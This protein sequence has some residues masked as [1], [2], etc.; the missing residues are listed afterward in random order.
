MQTIN[1]NH[2]YCLSKGHS[3]T[4]KNT[5]PWLLQFHW[6]GGRWSVWCETFCFD[7]TFLT[8]RCAWLSEFTK[9]FD[10]FNIYLRLI[11]KENLI[12]PALCNDSRFFEIFRWIVEMK[13]G[14]IFEISCRQKNF[15]VRITSALKIISLNGL[16]MYL[17]FAFKRYNM[18]LTFQCVSLFKANDH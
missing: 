7:N 17:C 2:D 5:Q 4:I 10:L 1:R 16:Q 8:S 9:L 11:L 18:A 12:L 14:K 3:I 13:L 6:C 15:D